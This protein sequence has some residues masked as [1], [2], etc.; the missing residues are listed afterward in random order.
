MTDWSSIGP[1][2]IT[3]FNGSGPDSGSGGVRSGMSGTV[4]TAG[5]AY[6]PLYSP[7][8]PLFW[9]AAL[10]LAGAGLLTISMHVKGG[11]AKASVSI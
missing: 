10:L 9:F 3:G 2:T 4:T 1:S 11:P 5:G 7:D 6:P 8:N